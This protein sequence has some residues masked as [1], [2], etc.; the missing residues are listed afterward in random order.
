MILAN[1]Q[2]ARFA[3]GTPLLR[4]NRPTVSAA[5]PARVVVRAERASWL[6]GSEIP[7]YL[8]GELPGDFGFDP[9]RLGEDPAAL[10][11]YQQA[12]LQNGRWAML[13]AAGI[14]FVDLLGHL[15]AGGPAAATPWFKASDFTY[16]A[17]TSTLFI[18]ELILFAWVEVRR[19]QDMVKPGSTNQDPIFSQYSL[20]SGNEPGYPGGIFDPLGYSKGNMAE[21]KLKEIKNAR[22]AM[23]AV[24]GFFVQAK[25]TGQTPLDSLASHLADPWSNNVFG[26]EH[27]RLIGK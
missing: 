2:T 25:T 20:P 19:Y 11:W 1:S 14:L 23:L 13:A 7:S 12:E 8:K 15:G 27:A 26:I 24:L 22:L 5:R 6:P 17:P 3:V 10:K 16:F 18:V 21:L 9:L 4:S